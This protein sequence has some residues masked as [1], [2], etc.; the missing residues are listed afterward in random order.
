M[1][2][3]NK[4]LAVLF[5][6]KCLGCKKKTKFCVRIASGKINRPDTPYL[7]GVHIAANYQDPVIKKAL[8]ML[9]Y[10]GVK[11]LAKPLAELIQERSMEKTGNGGL[12]D[13]SHSFV[14]KKLRHRGYNQAELIARE[15]SSN[16]I[17]ECLV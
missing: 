17:T 15:I 11:Q 5:P 14:K 13:C 4:I 1:R 8:W 10:Q 6:Q 12:A 7:K 9:K 2:I 16:I 3:F